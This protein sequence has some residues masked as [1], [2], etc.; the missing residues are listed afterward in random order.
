MGPDFS[1]Q[2]SNSVERFYRASSA[3][4]LIK[5]QVKV[6]ESDLWILSD[7]EIRDQV[8]KLLKI[9]RRQLKEYIYNHPDFATTL[10]PFPS[11]PEAPELVR[12][13]IEVSGKA[14]V[15]PMAAVAGTIAGFIGKDISSTCSEVIIENGGDIYLRSAVERVI[16]IYAGKSE[17]SKKVGVLLPA[18]PDGIGICTSAGTV[19]PSLSFGSA[20]AAVIISPDVALADSIATATA[21]RILKTSDL[22]KAIDF[23]SSISKITGIIVIKDD[24]MAAW[25]EVNLV[26]IE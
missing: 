26:P 19:G 8:A 12:K 22:Q 1:Y 2:K 18:S 14:G 24:K 21:N 17:F 10:K 16:S 15:G 9:Y 4:D 20:D 3:K 11:D 5:S 7:R 25:G 6:G 13:M 23:A